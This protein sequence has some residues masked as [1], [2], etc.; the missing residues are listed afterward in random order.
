M[1]LGRP[2]LALWF[3]LGLGLG[4]TASPLGCAFCAGLDRREFFTQ[5]GDFVGKSIARALAAFAHL[6]TQR[7]QTLTDAV[8]LAARRHAELAADV[9]DP[10]LHLRANAHLRI[11]QRAIDL[12]ELRRQ[13]DLGI[14]FL[15]RVDPQIVQRPQ[16]FDLAARLLAFREL[17]LEQFEATL[18]RLEHQRV[19]AAHLF[20][21]LD[22]D[23]GHLL[24]M[25]LM[26]TRRTE[27][28][29][30]EPRF[31]F[32][33]VSIRGRAQ[34]THERRETVAT[35]PRHFT[36][37]ARSRMLEQWR[38]AARACEPLRE[39][40]APRHVAA[41]GICGRHR[42]QRLHVGC[43][44]FRAVDQAFDGF[45]LAACAGREQPRPL[46]E[47]LHGSRCRRLRAGSATRRVLPRIRVLARERL[48]LIH[49]IG[50]R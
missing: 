8:E 6:A 37:G 23:H 43:I 44:A 20:L 47:A 11:D 46:F 21:V 18:A 33:Q 45:A 32:A 34:R 26:L 42:K 29:Q 35:L 16:R 13:G 40:I 39:R 30:I 41:L 5:P 2:D 27:R 3:G 1:L 7:L 4:G 12:A 31:Q 9:L 15:G 25:L 22:R 49:P 14:A 48:P 36:P 28:G 24:V 10:L 50:I 17:A 38:A 19:V